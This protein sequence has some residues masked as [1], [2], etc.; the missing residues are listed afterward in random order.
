MFLVIEFTE[1][2]N[3]GKL[4]LESIEFLI[5]PNVLATESAKDLYASLLLRSLSSSIR[6]AS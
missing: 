4:K 2:P 1:L 5:C 6:I 3:V